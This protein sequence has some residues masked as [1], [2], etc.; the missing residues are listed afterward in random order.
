MPISKVQIPANFTAKFLGGRPSKCA[1]LC[2]E[3]L[4]H[5]AMQALGA[6]WFA[7]DES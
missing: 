1:G 4:S 5:L 6:I 2:V 7:R 3:R